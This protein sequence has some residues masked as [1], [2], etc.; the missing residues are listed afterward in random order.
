MIPRG[1]LDV[2]PSQLVRGLLHSVRPGD[3]EVLSKRIAAEWDPGRHVHTCLSVRSG[4]HLLL[5]SLRW[6]PGT[7]VL[8]SAVNL[9]DMVRVLESH[10]LV[11]VPVDIDR[12][13]LTPTCEAVAAR[14]TPRTR[15]V[16]VAQLFGS[17]APLGALAGLAQER[18]LELWEDAA[19]AYAID[20]YRGYPAADVAF[21]SFGPIKTRTALAGGILSLRDPDRL[22]RCREIEAGWPRR[23]NA[24]FAKR[25]AKF[26][27][28]QALGTH[29]VYSVLTALARWTGRDHD[30]VISRLLRGFPAGD[31]IP[32]LA[33]RPSAALL[34]LLRERLRDRD[35]TWRDER[36][37]IAKQYR[38]HLPPEMLLGS[39]AA[40]PAPWVFPVPL[41]DPELG[42]SRLLEAGY[43]ATG[44]GSQLR[45]IPPPA[46]HPAWTTPLATEWHRS[47]LYLPMHPALTEARIEEVARILRSL[48]TG[49]G[50]PSSGR[51]PALLTCGAASPRQ[52]P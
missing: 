11:V 29:G 45:V 31:L 8:A 28:L 30:A 24:R 19:Q 26:L 4:L 51:A 36:I 37:R 52:A 25:I 27:I 3:P 47:L 41:P 43:D 22:A 50:I 16:L 23:S 42:R 38:T 49:D 14:I 40:F 6:P 15:A 32:Q 9:P 33:G 5:S 1:I 17:R 10:G 2:G 18:G 35:T 7:E 20:G 39:D 21:F 48:P 12:H 44:R 46:S 13:T 34:R